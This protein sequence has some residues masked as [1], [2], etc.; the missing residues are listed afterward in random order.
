MLQCDKGT[1]LILWV[2]WKFLFPIVNC[3]KI[4]D[5][6]R[7]TFGQE[8]DTIDMEYGHNINLW[9]EFLKGLNKSFWRVCSWTA[10]MSWN[11]IVS[12]GKTIGSEWTQNFKIVEECGFASGIRGYEEAH[13]RRRRRKW[14]RRWRNTSLQMKL[15]MNM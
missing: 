12:L 9:S 5:N 11:E 4:I 15:E 7:L 6:N 13:L 10:V 3:H 14:K 8:Y 2:F 1:N